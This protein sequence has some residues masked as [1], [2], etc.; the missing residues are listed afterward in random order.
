M[1]SNEP[2]I[3]QIRA[4]AKRNSLTTLLIGG[5]ALMLSILCLTF[6][7]QWLFLA[8][9]FMTSASIVALLVGWFKLREPEYSLQITPQSIV[10]HHR[11]GQWK[12]DWDNLIRVDQPSVSHGMEL[13]KLEMIGFKL[14]DPDPFIVSVSPRLATHLLMEQ[15]PLLLHHSS[16]NCAT[17]TC[18]DDELLNDKAYVTAD[19]TVL[20]GIKA[21]LANRMQILREQLGFDV[22]I[23][24]AELDRAP[25]EFAV[26][27]K[28]C[29]QTR[30]TL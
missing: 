4:T 18:Y 7:P 21:M 11:L 20:S 19:G 8:G 30:H 26:L 13:V 28:S 1:S 29:A 15:R 9:I 6:L 16:K 25:A 10:Y 14:K 3:I 12:I 27:L 23:A 17:G 5:G 2:Q 22:F 24:A